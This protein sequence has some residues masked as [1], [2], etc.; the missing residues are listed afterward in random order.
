M[1]YT[2]N[3]DTSPAVR[4]ACGHPGIGFFVCEEFRI[5]FR[6]RNLCGPLW[7][8]PQLCQPR[9]QSIEEKK[10]GRKK[11]IDPAMPKTDDERQR[12]RS[13]S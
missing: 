10:I 2:T 4:V 7:L 3:K 5:F 8:R 12:R 1:V 13:H 6:A 9:H 11:N